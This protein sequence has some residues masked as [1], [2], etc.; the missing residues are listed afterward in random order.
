MITA[1]RL[2]ERDKRKGYNM[3]VFISATSRT[4]YTAGEGGNPSPFRVV[5]DHRELEELD[6]FPQ[7]EILEFEGMEHI[8]QFVQQEMEERA[9]VGLPPVRAAILG[10]ATRRIEAKAVRP[11]MSAHERLAPAAVSAPS[12]PNA[13]NKG[14][15]PVQQRREEKR[16]APETKVDAEGPTRMRAPV[17]PRDNDAIPKPKP[18]P[19]PNVEDKTKRQLMSM[20][21]KMGLEEVNDR[22]KKSDIAAAIVTASR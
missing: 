13:T 11:R 14:R 18:K 6:R 15:Q 1:V 17:N 2:R 20:A 7:F 4:K 5:R 9:R 21:S 3:R 19:I 8:Q 22:M 10:G 12:D 16:G